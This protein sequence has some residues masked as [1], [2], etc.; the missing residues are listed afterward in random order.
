MAYVPQPKRPKL[1]HLRA[2]RQYRLMGQFDLSV[3]TGINI[4]VISHLERQDHTPQW[5]TIDRLAK[6]LDITRQQLVYEAPPE[7]PGEWEEKPTSHKGG[8]RR[9]Q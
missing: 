3:Q 7:A 5:R 1:I 6:A 4:S 9:K 8:R 2:W